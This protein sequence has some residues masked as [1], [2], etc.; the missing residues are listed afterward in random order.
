MRFSVFSAQFTAL[1]YRFINWLTGLNLNNPIKKRQYFRLSNFWATLY[2]YKN[3]DTCKWKELFVVLQKKLV[4]YWPT[5][6]SIFFN[7]NC[8]QSTLGFREGEVKTCSCLVLRKELFITLLH[9]TKWSAIVLVYCWWESF[10]WKLQPY[11][12][13]NSCN[14]IWSILSSKQ[15]L[16]YRFR[17]HK[18]T[19]RLHYEDQ[20][21]QDAGS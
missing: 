14:T 8:L 9:V 10:S 21:I 19:M 7:W 13:L 2:I 1:W 20:P 12:N 15:Y 17:H 18:N 6:C 5:L 16:K 11:L 4:T 3:I